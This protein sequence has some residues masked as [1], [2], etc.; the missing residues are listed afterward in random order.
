MYIEI[1]ISLFEKWFSIRRE[2]H[3]LKAKI[4]KMR[5][6]GLETELQDL[7]KVREALEN[8]IDLEKET[9]ASAQKELREFETKAGALGNLIASIEPQISQQKPKQREV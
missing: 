5:K 4:R 9:I 1:N 3:K 2:N 8:K 7:P 6:T